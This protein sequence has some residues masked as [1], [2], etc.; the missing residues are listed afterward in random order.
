M[1]IEGIC[2]AKIAVDV[3]LLPI[4]RIMDHAIEIN[5]ELLKQCPDKII[6]NKEDG[7]PHISLAM[8]C[9]EDADIAGIEE[10]LR[11]IA[12]SHSPGPLYSNGIRTGFN[13]KNE[14]VSLLDL[15]KT[16]QLQLLH[17]IVMRKLASFFSYDVSVDMV[18]SPPTAGESTLL[19][20]RDYPEKSSYE[21]FSPHI[22]LG[23]GQLNNISF[24]AEFT[25][26]KLALCHL[27]NH[28]TCRK[29]LASTALTS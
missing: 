25:A 27:G 4:E 26:P 11:N 19:W 13:A 18:L 21:Q 1:H 7:L 5:R 16:Q 29:I 22:T 28:C 3:V 9:I 10:I 24:P 8:G 15:R 17:E 14:K 23:Y 2:M 6:L 12:V 20:I